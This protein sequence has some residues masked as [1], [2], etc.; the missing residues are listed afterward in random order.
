[1]NTKIAHLIALTFFKLSH[2][3]AVES[4]TAEIKLP[5]EQPRYRF[6]YLGGLMGIPVSSSSS[7]SGNS[8]GLGYGAAAGV[9]PV[10][11]WS[12]GGF[13]NQQAGLSWA[14]LNT[15][16]R[17]G[18]E[19]DFF[20]PTSDTWSFS[21]GYRVGA[22]R[23]TGASLFLYTYDFTGTGHGPKLSMVKKVSELFSFGLELSYFVFNNPQYNST[24][25]LGSNSGKSIQYLSIT[26]A[27]FTFRFYL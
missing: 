22:A 5:V 1:M 19:T 24:S 7:L 10:N 16:T 15:A 25:I 13:Y 9:R 27:N 21:A 26:D 14:D 4:T 23:A 6:V 17:Y 8:V 20:I 2:A 18:V 11:F 3:F 12:I